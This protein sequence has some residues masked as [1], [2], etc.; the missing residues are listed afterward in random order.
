MNLSYEINPDFLLVTFD[1]RVEESFPTRFP[2]RLIET[3]I[4]H[5][6]TRILAD[7]RKVEGTL[8]TTQRHK[9]GET[10]ARKYFSALSKGEISIC[11]FALVA[12]PPLLDP[13]KFGETVATNRGMPVRIFPSFQEAQDW[14]LQFPV[15]PE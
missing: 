6:C 5:K 4:T 7:L 15:P 8:T 11:K 9:M 13:S 10:G 14:L 2:E 1:G 3:A 12:D